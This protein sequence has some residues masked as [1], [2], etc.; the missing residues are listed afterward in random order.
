MIA[1]PPPGVDRSLWLYEICRL[2]VHKVNELVIAFFQ[3]SPPCS[4]ATCPE[5]RASEWQYLCAVHDPPK[6]CCAIDYC[7]HTLDW[8]AM[9]LTSQ[10]HFPSRLT[11]GSD[12][13][14][15]QAAERHI[16][17]IFRRVYRIFAHGWFQHR[18]IFWT[19]EGKWGH[20][21]FFKAVCD[22]YAL[23]PAENYTIPPEAEGLVT[24]ADEGQGAASVAIMQQPSG[25]GEQ[26]AEDS[27]TTT[28]IS[29]GATTRRHKHTPSTGSAVAIIQEDE[30]DEPESQPMIREQAPTIQRTGT[31]PRDPHVEEEGDDEKGKKPAEES[32]DKAVEDFTISEPVKKTEDEDKGSEKQATEGASNVEKSE[33]DVS[34]Q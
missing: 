11:L 14:G 25:G 5:M 29:T 15:K 4:A 21:A 8:A 32:L 19:V 28:T 26:K 7:C 6:S 1:N 33:G 2:L 34:G 24:S 17:N 20:Y 31:E 9:I 23:I 18:Q 3:D 30:E 10:K 22:V 16:T 27:D 12:S 13:A